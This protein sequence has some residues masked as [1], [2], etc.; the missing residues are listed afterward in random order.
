MNTSKAG[1]SSYV[2]R[3]TSPSTGSPS[4]L[5]SSWCHR[6]GSSWAMSGTHWWPQ[7]Q[8]HVLIQSQVS[9]RHRSLDLGEGFLLQRGKSPAGCLV[10]GQSWVA[11]L[12]GEAFFWSGLCLGPAHAGSSR[13]LRTQE[14]CVGSTV[15]S[16]FSLT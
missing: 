11:F 10:T 13:V 5:L 16:W 12:G 3:K 4:C 6:Q 7:L 14:R 1:N 2:R 8:C 9:S 15:R